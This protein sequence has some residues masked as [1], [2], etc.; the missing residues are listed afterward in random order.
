[1]LQFLQLGKKYISFHE[2]DSA[3]TKPSHVF[4]QQQCQSWWQGANFASG[5]FCPQGRR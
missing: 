4:Q 2:Y 3:A 5:C 1:M